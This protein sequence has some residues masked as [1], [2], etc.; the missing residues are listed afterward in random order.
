[1]CMKPTAV[2]RPAPE[3]DHAFEDLGRRSLISSQNGILER[4]LLRK[5]KEFYADLSE[6]NTQRH[7]IERVLGA[8]NVRCEVAEDDRAQIPATGSLVVLANHP[9]G[10]VDGL[11][12]A[13]IVRSVRPD[14]KIL[15]NASLSRVRELCD[16]LIHVDPYGKSDSIQAN[17]RSVREAIE[18]VRNGGALG[19][20]PAGEISHINLRKRE[21]T[22]PEWHTAAARIIRRTGAPS[23]PVFL[24][25]SNGLLFQLAGLVHPSLRTAMLP[26]ELLNKRGTRIEAR[27]GR[28][29]STKKLVALDTD[30]A[31]IDYLRRRTYLLSNRPS[32]TIA[33]QN[34]RAKRRK[35]KQRQIIAALP[36][37]T[38]AKELLM[39]PGDQAL[40]ST[41]SYSVFHAHA[42]QIPNILLEIG[43]LREISFRE[44]NEGTGKAMDLDDFDQHYVHLFL[45]NHETSEIVGAYRLGHSDELVNRFGRQGLYTSTLFDYGAD[46]IR[47][48]NPALELGRSFVRPEYQMSFPPLF[49]LWKGIA[50][51]VLKHPQYETLFGPVSIG[52]DYQPIA[53]RLIVECLA[54]PRYAHDLADMVKPRSPFRSR[55]GKGSAL[56]AVVSDIEE[57][58]TLIS[59]IDKDRRGIPVL[60][61]QYLKLGGKL[62]G[63]NVDPSFNDVLDGLILV[64]LTK[65]DARLLARLM[66]EDGMERYLGL[67]RTRYR[68]AS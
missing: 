41:G 65:T 47:R 37:E 16:T 64:D 29:V 52:N 23:L 12:L 43:R 49:L 28:L 1:L 17:S 24:R 11:V 56:G 50:H 26:R 22:D 66:G 15:A 20:F 46:F 57:V 5:L 25:G 30:D 18:W 10:M 45:W 9:F 34:T 68:L 40:I 21:V 38:L 60:L 6:G 63:F 42:S 3:P 2:R 14:F 53:R 51:Y 19:I 61:R 36:S 4:M 44:V 59:D 67:H 39:L 58:S 62:L 55:A 7:F 48:I 54:G 32:G 27:I 33:D 31:L 8:L 13:S 35:P